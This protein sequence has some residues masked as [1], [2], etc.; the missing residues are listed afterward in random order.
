[1]DI[2]AQYDK[3]R[4]E[5]L[6]AHELKV[7]T[8]PDERLHAQCEDVTTFD[9]EDNKFLTQLF[10]DM[11]HTMVTQQGIG[12]AAPQV[13]VMINFL[14]ILHQNPGA[15]KP[16]PIALVNPKIVSS[17]EDMFEWEEGCLSVPG[18]FENRKRP[19][20]V[21]VEFQD[22]VGDKFE[23]EFHGLYAFVVQHEIDHLKG[24]LFIDNMSKLKKTLVVK[25]KMR[26]YLKKQ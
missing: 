16:E 8:W 10:L 23:M 5:P 22:L 11:S 3:E 24:K 7:I 2:D 14:V 18:F 1:M 4:D 15:K 6:K 17:S 12:L 20:V 26:N 25:K 9:D 13:A 21:V 19:K